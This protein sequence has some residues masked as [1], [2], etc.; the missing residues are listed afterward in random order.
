MQSAPAIQKLLDELER[1]PGVGPKSAQ[2]MAYWILNSDRAMALR[3]AQAIVEVKDAVHFCSR[4][5]NYAEDD[6][7]EICRSTSRNQQ[8]LCVVSEPR[9]IPPIERTAVYQGL[10]HVLGG[11][12]SPMD[13]IGPDDLHIAQLMQRLATEDVQEVVLAT[14]PNVEGETTAAYLAR[15]IKPLGI[16]VTRLASGL[17]VGG[18]LEFADEV[19]LGRALE[20]RRVL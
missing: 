11:A 16:K 17:P 12:L 13:G 19:T 4:C 14:N 10:Y 1:L 20:A 18:D 3:L 6:L 9:D 8:L 7:C 5:F 15:L 2:R